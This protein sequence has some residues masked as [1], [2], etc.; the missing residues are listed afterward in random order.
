LIRPVRLTPAAERDLLRLVD[1]LI[2]KN[3]RA[4]DRAAAAIDAA[5][6]SLDQFSD[7]GRQTSKKGLRE[8]VVRFGQ[9]A[10]IIQ[11]RVDSDAVVVARVFHN[12]EKR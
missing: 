9:R 12:L 6:R 3:P 10:Y 2:E 7:R 11:Y 1:F 4:A 5:I 8:L